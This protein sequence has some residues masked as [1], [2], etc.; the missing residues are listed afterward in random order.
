M[1][2]RNFLSLGMVILSVACGSGTP[3]SQSCT[4]DADCGEFKCLRDK[5]SNSSNMCVDQPVPDGVCSPPCT[6]HADCT[7]Y[8]A[9]F[10]CAL[11]QTDI[12]CNP[13]GICLD[14]YHI[15]CTPGPCRE[16][17]AS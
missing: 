11:S 10:K 6:T 12:A 17:P 5:Y 14:D 7:K 13:T 3:V 16:A 8:G 4:S 2:V 15:S 9:T 1:N